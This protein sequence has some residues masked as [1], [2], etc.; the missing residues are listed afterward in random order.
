MVTEV[1][2]IAHDPDASMGDM[3]SFISRDQALTLR[4]LK[5]ANSSFYGCSREVGSVRQAITVLG[6][7]QIQNIASALALAPMFDMGDETL[8]DGPHL[9]AHGLATALWTQ[10]L[11]RAS[12]LPHEANLF[13][14]ALL[15]DIGLVLLLRSEPEKM[16]CVLRSV[17]DL[18]RELTAA[19]QD[20]FG[21]DHAKI[22]ASACA[23]WKLPQALA[24]LIASHESPVSFA[25][26]SARLL[27]AAERLASHTGQAAFPWM[28]AAALATEQ[29]RDLGISSS[30]ANDLLEKQLEIRTASTTLFLP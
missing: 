23:A 17:R 30:A 2:R 9:W 13:T 12:G 25:H 21:T 27:H 24:N 18:G 6:T 8:V 4:V 16:T 10:V 7:E 1:L 15:H 20:M 3:E 22:G 11:A 29:W 14:A 5:V 26:P 19:E 28:R